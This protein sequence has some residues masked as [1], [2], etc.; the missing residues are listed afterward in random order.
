MWNKLI[1]LRPLI[2]FGIFFIVCTLFYAF[3]PSQKQPLHCQ[4]LGAFFTAFSW[5][6][7]AC[8]FSLY[9]RV[10][11]FSTYL[12]GSLSYLILFLIYLYLFMYLFFI[13]AEINWYVKNFGIREKTF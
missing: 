9:L 12:Y 6:L 2:A 3:L 13:G 1:V 7:G 8:L 5:M 10:S 4:Y 11:R